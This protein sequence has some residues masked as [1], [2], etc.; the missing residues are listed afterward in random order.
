MKTHITA[1]TLCLLFTI[2][3]AFPAS[4][5]ETLTGRI[6][7]AYGFYPDKQLRAL[8][9]LDSSEYTNYQL[10]L[11]HYQL[12]CN[13]DT[14]VPAEWKLLSKSFWLVDLSVESYKIT[15]NIDGNVITTKEI[16]FDQGSKPATPIIIQTQ[17]KNLN[18]NQ[19]KGSDSLSL[20]ML[21]LYGEL[22]FKYNARGMRDLAAIGRQ[23]FDNDLKIP[24]AKVSE[25]W[26]DDGIGKTFV[27]FIPID[28]SQSIDLS[29]P[30][31]TPAPASTNAD[32][33]L[34]AKSSEGGK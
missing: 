25:I 18:G 32:T 5:S 9:Y 15:G 2:L 14:A 28:L 8:L 11:K 6:S 17:D 21:G 4:A 26:L 16:A 34:P 13:A 29:K 30:A 3:L 7:V 33:K 24:I 27:H 22:C 20:Q 10:K 12:K 23:G 31:T 1:A 19:S